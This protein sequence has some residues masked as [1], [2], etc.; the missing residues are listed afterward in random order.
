MFTQ[1]TE[2]LQGK[3]FND[4]YQAS[5]VTKGFSQGVKY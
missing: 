2:N 5:G 4:K 3:Q 1:E